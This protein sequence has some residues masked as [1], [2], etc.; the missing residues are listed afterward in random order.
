MHARLDNKLLA[1]EKKIKRRYDN[2]IAC[3]KEKEVQS[4]RWV[5]E[6]ERSGNG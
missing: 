3:S 1:A 6:S 2:E 4:Y 5:R